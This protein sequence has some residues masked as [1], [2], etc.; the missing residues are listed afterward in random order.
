[1]DS[2][3]LQLRISPEANKVLVK[4]ATPR[5][6]GKLL[7][8]LITRFVNEDGTISDCSDGVLEQM[9]AALNAR[10][11]KLQR[12]LEDSDRPNK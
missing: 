7:S 4:A 3:K 6:R 12:T 8:E 5:Q 9:S 11:D 1:M 10:F 2:V